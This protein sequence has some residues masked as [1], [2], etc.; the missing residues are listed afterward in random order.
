VTWSRRSASSR[1]PSLAVTRE[2]GGPDVLLVHGGASPR[3]TWAGLEALAERWSLVSVH[4]RGYPP[5]P[6]EP[7][8]RQDFDVDAADLDELLGDRPHVV[9]HSYGSLGTLI[10]AGRTPERFRSLTVIEPPL[11]H[12]VAGDPDVARLDRLGDAVLT[13]GLDTDP[14]ELREFLRISGA[15][16]ITDGP[17][18]ED[19]ARGIRRAHGGRLPR[20]A[21]PDLAAIRSAGVPV[22]VASGDHTAGLETICDFLAA[23]LDAERVVAPGAGHFVAQAPGFA[24]R[25]EE[26]LS[27]VA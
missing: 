21:R 8:D 14:A 25:L 15:P 6:P 22:L 27:S 16:G 26:F 2:G 11:A 24:G 9:A 4:R 17:L 18:P 12:L 7:D 10:A 19:V 20:E 23:Q 1:R 5:S 3:T 13:H